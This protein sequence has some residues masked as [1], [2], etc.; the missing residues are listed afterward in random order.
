MGLALV[1]ALS[2]FTFFFSGAE[3]ADAREGV[4][5]CPPG[6]PGPND[7]C[8]ISETS[9]PISDGDATATPP[10]LPVT[11]ELWNDNPICSDMGYSFG[12]K[13]DQSLISSTD[14][15][16][17]FTILND[18]DGNA[19]AELTGGA[20]EDLT[21]WIEVSSTDGLHLTWESS[22]G[23]D[24]VFVKG[25]NVGGNLYN[26]DPEAT[27][28]SGLSTPNATH[29]I[30]HIEFC[31][32]YEL[33]AEKT[34]NA[35]YTRTYDWAITKDA[36]GAYE[37]FIGDPAFNHAYTISVDQTITDSDWAVTG[38]IVVTNPT[39]FTVDFA[40][41]DIVAG[42]PATVS[43]PTNSL[44]PGGSVTCTYDADLT[45]A[46][47]G[48]NTA[49]ISS[50]NANVLGATATDDYIFGDPTVV[51]GYSDIDVTDTNGESWA[52]SND[53][54]WDYTEEFSCPTDTSLYIDG[55]YT[56]THENIATITQ[57]GQSDT[58]IVTVQCYIWDVSKTANGS[59]NNQYEWDITKTVD[60]ESQSGLAGDTLEWTWSI[61]WNSSF[62]SEVNH[63]VEGVITVNN[64][65]NMELTVDVADQLSGG[66]AATVTCNDADGGTALTIAA[67]GSG[68]CDY[69]AAPGSQL[70]Q[71]T[72]TA[73]R[74]GVSV[75]DTVD[76]TW[77][78]GDDIGLDAA[79]SDSDNVTIPVDASQPFEYTESHTC[80]TV[81]TDYGTN[82]GSYSGDASN[83]ATITWTDGSD[84]ST[85]ITDYTCYIWDVSKTANGSYNNQY[86]WDITKTVD[87]ESQS[88][89]AGDTLEWTWSITWNS[90]FVSEVNHAVEGVITVNNPSNM[91][92][93]VDVADQL[94]GGFAATVTC[95]DADG[96]TALTIAANGSGTCDYTAAPGSQLAQ[97]TATATRNG[98]SVSDT[99]DVT[100]TQGDDIGLDAA[101]SDS[102]NVTIPVDASQPFEYTESHTCSTVTTDYGTNTGSYSGDASNTA[103]ITWTDGSDSSTAITDYTCYIWDVS[104]TANGSYNNQYEWDITKTVDPESQSGL[105]GDT[106]EWTWSITWN[107]SFVS[108]VNHAVEG[109]ITVNNPSNMELTVDVADQ[110]S[111]GFAATVTCN[112]ADGGTALTIAA[113]GSGT[114]DYTAA[115][116][117][118]LAQNTAT[119]T[120]N[121]VSVSDTVDVTWTQGDDIGLDAAISD[122]DNVTIPVDA[123][124]PFEY[125]ESHTCSTVTTD[126]GTN[127]GSY[128]GDASNTATIT[129]TD[130]S[131]SSTAITTYTCLLP[132]HVQ[133]VKTTNGGSSETYDW[134]FALFSGPNYGTGSGFLS[135]PLVT[136]STLDDPD[137]ILDFGNFDLD[138]REAY[139]VCELGT[140]ASAGWSSNWSINGVPVA[141]YDPHQFDNDPDMLGFFCV[142]IGV[143]TDYPLTAGGTLTFDVDNTRDGDGGQRTP[144]YWKNWSSCTNGN[145]YEHATIGDPDGE[146]WALDE[147]L[148]L[149][150]YELGSL[151]LGGDGVL[152]SPDCEDAVSIL[153]HTDLRGKK[154]ASDAA[155]KLARNLLAYELNQ[156]AGACHSPTAEAAA[157]DAHE[158]LFEIEFDGIGRFLRPRDGDDY[159]YALGLA[160]TLDEYNNGSLCTQ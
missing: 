116:G 122:S 155:Y 24:A 147:L 8:R 120:R 108:E 101:I 55:V 18:G 58:A 1:L 31:Y 7:K 135:D 2:A 104:K 62:V 32:D 48:T 25:G 17:Y 126:Y 73:T 21:N 89:L 99:V 35:E 23:I 10:V 129:W 158:L 19:I 59:Y 111:G 42:T 53:N 156:D 84:S 149:N 102:D 159:V 61:I 117:S 150:V 95:N 112:D 119:A 77:T 80:S 76:V 142:D 46:T 127:T 136:D 138:P 71:N 153:N 144:G 123:S 66:F 128:S 160:S 152:P 151:M 72:A 33:T 139:T 16:Y 92:L 4:V 5:D 86:E 146:F 14:T 67:N 137:G 110:L 130:G 87:P 28:D 40:V 50:S 82:T 69:T 97:N 30:S 37:G 133:V 39:P 148:A 109:V 115:P 94:S 143:D 118:Q 70:A 157:E 44:D 90:S 15:T 49:T 83:T 107:S 12:F 124:Q 131:D 140:N 88:G 114:C 98:V 68:T 22:L 43:C 79:I 85:A 113:N 41:E 57:T 154:R 3:T 20:P 45:G 105:A 56:L 145:Q 65:S 64:P 134:Q 26:Y 132:A 60:P 96:G 121:G 9:T 36:D 63:A 6:G 47:D 27:G 74:N 11:P 93:T 81:T 34:A 13:L 51:N 141:T 103:T 29:A 91:E 78:Q 75:S 52:T 125:T 100:W 38:D 54:S 106:L